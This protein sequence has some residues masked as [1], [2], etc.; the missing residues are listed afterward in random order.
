MSSI[1]IEIFSEVEFKKQKRNIH[2]HL[3][4]LDAPQLHMGRWPVPQLLL[5]IQN[6]TLKAI[7]ITDNLGESQFHCQSWQWKMSGWEKIHC[8]V[9]FFTVKARIHCQMW[10]F[11]TVNFNFNKNEFNLTANQSSTKSWSFCQKLKLQISYVAYRMFQKSS[12][13]WF[14]CLCSK[15][16]TPDFSGEGFLIYE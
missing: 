9:P 7:R 15:F 13:T 12:R 4:F 8:Q 3:L 14:F 11:F 16:G 1:V 2:I 6:T 5:T 10:T